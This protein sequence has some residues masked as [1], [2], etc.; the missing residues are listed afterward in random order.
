MSQRVAVALTFAVGLILAVGSRSWAQAPGE[1]SAQGPG[2]QDSQAPRRLEDAL[3][4]GPITPAQA[5]D[6]A[7][8]ALRIAETQGPQSPKG[9][10]AFASVDRYLS[11]VFTKDP[12][13]ARA[14]FYRARLMIVVGRAAEAIPNIRRWIN[15]L[16]GQNDWEGH[17]I[18]GE[19]YVNGAY[20]KLARPV[21]EK[22]L[23]LSPLEPRIHIALSKC[24]VKLLDRKNAEFYAEKA[25]RILEQ[26]GRADLSVYILHAD[27]LLLQQKP[28][29]AV[30]AVR[31]AVGM[32]GKANRDA[33]GSPATLSALAQ[34]YAKYQEV[35][36]GSLQI[37]PESWD[38]YVALAVVIEQKAR[39]VMRLASYEA[40]LVI[41]RSLAM[42]DQA[43]V[44][45]PPE[46]LMIKDA[47]LLAAVGKTSEAIESARKLLALYPANS[48]A[49]EILKALVQ[50]DAVQETVPTVGAQSP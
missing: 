29:Q 39:I 14:L 31:K 24:C 27:A 9:K 48:E 50:E 8:A 26:H 38:H 42:A 11:L 41:K 28:D 15:T 12:N 5:L 49:P 43:G 46:D 32:A 25:V 7:V 2:E 45:P 10:D 16:H 21:L 40:L 44:H 4:E 34:T 33:G 3:K 17:L 1:Q 6:L 23:Q 30:I 37:K 13:N 18:L 22:A 36:K 20:Y 19:I 35:L 47:K